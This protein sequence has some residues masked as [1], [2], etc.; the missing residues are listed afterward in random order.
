[1]TDPNAKAVPAAPHPARSHCVGRFSFSLPQD[2]TRQGQQQSIYLLKVWTEP[3]PD[4]TTPKQLLHHHAG[5]G[6][7]TV[8][9]Q[10]ALAGGI[11]LAHQ[12]P[13]GDG[14]ALRVL[15]LQ[16]WGGTMLLGQMDTTP[17][18]MDAAYQVIAQVLPSWRAQAQ[19]GFCLESGALTIAP[20]RNERA[21]MALGTSADVSLVLQTET[22]AQ[23]VPLPDAE[24]DAQDARALAAGGGQL[25]LLGRAERTLAGLPGR[26]RLLLL[27]ADAQSAPQLLYRWEHGGAPA[28]AL[29]PRVQ[30][31]LQGPADQRPRLDQAWALVSASLSR[32]P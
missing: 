16:P 5:S 17:Q 7:G 15:A 20:S 10:P 12:R 32:R 24:G 4:R 3:L 2:W 22:V 14:T 29:R 30:L 11:L 25:T 18:R 31:Q 28:D 19:S 8:S 23:P 26:E 1:M 13:Q 27:K 6:G 21:R 9:D